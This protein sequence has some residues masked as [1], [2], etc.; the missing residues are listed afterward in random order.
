MRIEDENYEGT[1]VQVWNIKKAKVQVIEFGNMKRDSN[2]YKTMK[3]TFKADS[4]ALET[5][6]PKK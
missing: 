3:V 2:F 5:L 6:E 1:I 4:L